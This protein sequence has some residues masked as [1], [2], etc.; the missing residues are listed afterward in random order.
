MKAGGHTRLL[1][2]LTRDDT[3]QDLSGLTVN[4]P[5]GLTGKIAGV[6]LCPR[7]K[8]KL[9]TCPASSRIGSVLTGAGAGPDPFYLPG[10]V[11]LTGP[12]KGAPFGLSIVVRAIAGPFDLG[13]VMVRGQIQV[14]RHTA[15]LHVV[16]D[17]LPTILQ[18][19]PLQIRDVR[20]TIDRKKFLINPTGC[21]ERRISARV[22][23]TQ[24]RVARPSDRFQV[25]GCSKLPLTPKF[26]L[27]VGSKGHTHHGDSV[28]FSTTL[29]ETPGQTNLK[30]VFVSLPL[31]LSSQLDVVNRACTQAQFEAHHCEQARAGSAVAVTP[32]LAHP[33][34]G[35]AYFVKDPSKPAGS[36]PNLVVGLRGQ[37]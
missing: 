31:T 17:P 26:K 29:T 5:N 11:F 6:P 2:R 15:Q 37:V 33:L 27:A 9:G 14:D 20:V 30:S 35:G 36:L 22:T 34:R 16:S 24:G 10:N 13:T 7:A 8:A 18:G 21:D 19:I 32:L 3:D 25:D 1:V 28:P 12:Y 23:S 4:S